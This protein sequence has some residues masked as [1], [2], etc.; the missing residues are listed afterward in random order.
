MNIRETRN[1]KPVTR[2]A[3]FFLVSV[4]W[5]LVTISH[6]AGERP[7]SQLVY[8]KAV[9]AVA[10]SFEETPDWAP[11]PD[12][13]APVD[14]NLQTRWAPKSSSDNEWIYFDLG[15]EKVISKITI[16]WEDAYAVKYEILASS[17]SKSWNRVI[18]K[19]EGRGGVENLEFEP[20]KA[21]FVKIAALRRVN[22]EWGFSMWEFEI[23]GPKGSNPQDKTLEETFP[24]RQESFRAARIASC[25]NIAPGEIVRS[26]GEISRGEFHKGINYTSWNRSELGS[27]ISDSSLVYLSE[28]GAKHAAIM[29]VWYQPNAKARFIGPTDKRS[30]SDECLAHAINA[31]H[32]LGMK[33]MLKPHVD[34]EDGDYRT[35]IVPSEEWFDSYKK[36]ILHYAEMA[37]KYNVEIFSVGTELSNTTTARWRK[38]WLEILAEV[39]KIYKGPIIYGANWDEYETVSFWSEVDYIGIDAYFP[40]TRKKDPT[41]DELIA[42][43]KAIADKLEAWLKAGGLAAKGI[44]FTEIG[45]DAVDGSNIEPWRVLSTIANQKEDQK[46]QA[47]CLDSL[48]IVLSKRPWFKGFY[49]WNYFPRPD[50]GPLGYTLRGK[51]GEKILVE[52]FKKK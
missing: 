48:M 37:A 30:V 45:Y 31:S 2:N 42:A 39:R 21:R 13:M 52:W 17:D 38:R 23:Y 3:I 18:L 28:L 46:E 8:L 41:K 51:E 10:S 22:P 34:L 16:N 40:L 44:I 4:L 11:K 47:D 25:V 32:R 29:A 50:L 24:K 20:V 26:P 15:R 7:Q 36:F 5:F 1:Q 14:G 33:V 9:S 12:P 43:W 27:Q 35:N 19:D 49:W 6:A